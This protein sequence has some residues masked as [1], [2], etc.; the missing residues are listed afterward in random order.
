MFEAPGLLCIAL[1]IIYMGWLRVAT[2]V[3]WMVT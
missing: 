1:P 2:S 3:G